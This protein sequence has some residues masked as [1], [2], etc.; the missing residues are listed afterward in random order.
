[1]KQSKTNIIKESKQLLISFEENLYTLKGLLESEHQSLAH[2]RFKQ[3]DEITSLKYQ[4]LVDLEKTSLALA[5]L[6]DLKNFST[7]SITKNLKS[8][9]HEGIFLFKQWQKSQTTLK[10][11]TKKNLINGK[12]IAVSKKSNKRLF[13]IFFPGNQERKYT[14]KGQ[15]KK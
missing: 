2:R 13:D 15:M 6:W 14:D 12:L 3:L 4:A 1:M 7:E 11:L 10:L 9:G 5:A 8:L